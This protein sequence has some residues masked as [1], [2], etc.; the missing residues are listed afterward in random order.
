MIERQNQI[1]KIWRDNRWLWFLPGLIIGFLIGLPINL[2][3]TPTSW[4]VEGIWPEAIGIIFTVLIIDRFY[5]VIKKREQIRDAQE[6]YVN[7]QRIYIKRLEHAKAEDRLA[8][9]DEMKIQNMFYGANLVGV[10]LSNLDLTRQNLENA[11]L[12]FAD[13]TNVLLGGANLRNANLR[14][15]NLSG[16][17]LENAA[18]EGA[19]IVIENK[20]IRHAGATIFNSNTLL[21]NTQNYTTEIDIEQ[22]TNPEHSNFF[23]PDLKH[24]KTG[25]PFDK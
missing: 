12:Q 5:R 15:A 24:I 18:L 1:A 14:G 11:S 16:A 20:M 4:F 19:Q 3:E 17:I 8:I 2:G 21:P 10:N 13:L 25:S 22:F 6:V 23:Q 7:K 9:I